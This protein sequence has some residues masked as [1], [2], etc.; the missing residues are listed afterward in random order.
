MNV[1][2]GGQRL[3]RRRIY[4]MRH[5]RVDYFSDEVLKARDHRVARLTE[6]GRAQAETA[7]LALA[8]P[9]LTRAL[10]SG[11]TRTRETAEIVL[12]QRARAP[13]LTA[14][15][16]LEEIRGGTVAFNGR[17]E[18]A[19]AMA[20][21]FA[22]AHEPGARMFDGESFVDAQ[23]RAVAAIRRVVLSPEPVAER[24]ATLIV[25]HEGVNRLI[26]SW[27]CG[28]GLAAA[29]AFEQDT[30]CVNVLDFDLTSDGGDIGRII[31]KAVN[32][33]PYNWLKHG[34]SRTSLEAIFAAD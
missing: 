13:V 22:R 28:A 4:L 32:I 9:V 23:A 18:A 26:L 6:E 21:Q 3:E 15:G 8:E 30:C 10:S 24:G 19:V 2:S 20:A 33:T 29:S 27:A 1:S 7:G 11:L 12:A 31:V 16:D 34:M 25:A 5:G 14:D 17:A